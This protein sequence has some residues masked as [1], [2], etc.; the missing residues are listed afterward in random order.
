MELK[1]VLS[2]HPLF[3]SLLVYLEEKMAAEW[4]KSETFTVAVT[5]GV[6]SALP[7]PVMTAPPPAFLIVLFLEVPPM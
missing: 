6:T 7:C 1:Y 4:L 5:S 3:C 2:L